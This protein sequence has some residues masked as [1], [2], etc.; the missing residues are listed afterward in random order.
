MTFVIV[1]LQSQF[2][3]EHT[4]VQWETCVNLTIFFKVIHYLNEFWKL[5]LNKFYLKMSDSSSWGK[6]YFIQFHFLNI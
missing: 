6:M 3:S 4:Q 2:K 5:V 1:T